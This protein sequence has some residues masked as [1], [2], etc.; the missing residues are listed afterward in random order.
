MT[1]KEEKDIETL[2]LRKCVEQTSSEEETDHGGPYLFIDLYPLDFDR[3]ATRGVIEDPPWESL[4]ADPRVTGV[5]LKAT[6]GIRWSD[7]YV[8]WFV[9]NF[10]RVASLVGDRRGRSFVLGGYSFVQTTLSGRKQ[11]D[12]MM[13]VLQ[14]AGWTPGV[15]MVPVMD[16]E[17]GGATHPNR[18]A[19]NQ[20]VVDAGHDFSE[21]V[22]ELTGGGT[23][24]YGR[25]TMRD[26]KIV[27][28]FGADRV[29]NPSYTA[30]M[31]VNGLIP[32]WTLDDI[33]LWQYCGDGV[34]DSSVTKLPLK[35]AGH[36]IDLSVAIHGARKPTLKSTIQRL[37]AWSLPR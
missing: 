18:K 23:M 4:L 34:G 16:I 9:R 3:A 25:G 12:Y 28:T 14:Q 33:V 11:A 19:T 21:R 6:D 17:E 1:D 7:A 24:L 37:T 15:D 26:R 22:R 10:R 8:H 20:Q 27:D 2:E 35:M 29:A 5:W 30:R 13:S 36:G 31:V 32:P